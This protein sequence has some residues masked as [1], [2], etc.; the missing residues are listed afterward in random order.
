MKQERKSLRWGGGAAVLGGLIWAT[1]FIWM[2]RSEG[3]PDDPMRI[4][5]SLAILILLLLGFMMASY[6]LSR[7][8]GSGRV[9]LLVMMGGMGL[10][11]IG[12]MSVSLLQIGVAWLAGILGEL[13]TSI[14]LAWFALAN[15]SDKRLP[16]L[17]GLP[18]LMLLLY[19]P[20]WMVDPGNLL[21]QFPAHFTEWL[22]AVYG[23]GWVGLGGL[24]LLPGRNEA[25]QEPRL[26]DGGQ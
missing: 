26:A 17:N 22:A 10:M 7:A 25:K 16:A 11:L 2:S 20:S 24:M 13:V 21:A 8:A 12:V 4:T 23:L 18:L 15:L 14:G 9:G 3:R 5:G 6:A 19:V 1:F